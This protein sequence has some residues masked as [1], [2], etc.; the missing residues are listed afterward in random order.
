MKTKLFIL[1][2]LIILS[3]SSQTKAQYGHAD[4]V[5]LQATVNSPKPVRY[6][7]FSLDSSNISKDTTIKA[8]SSSSVNYVSNNNFRMAVFSD[9][10]E[11]LKLYSDGKRA[12]NGQHQP[13]DTTLYSPGTTVNQNVAV[14]MPENRDLV[15]IFSLTTDSSLSY[16]LI[17]INGNN[18]QGSVVISGQQFAP[19][20][21][22]ISI[23]LTKH[24]NGRDYWLVSKKY[25]TNKYVSFRIKPSGNVDT[26]FSKAGSGQYQ[27]PAYGYLKFS[28][29]GQWLG[30][31]IL[32]KNVIDTLRLLN[33][34]AK[35]GTVSD[36]NIRY[37]PCH[38]PSA[39]MGKPQSYAFSPNSRFVYV[40][41]NGGYNNRF[42][43]YDLTTHD[44]QSFFNSRIM[45]KKYNPPYGQ[46][47]E[48][49]MGLTANGKIYNPSSNYYLNA[50]Y[51]NSI[52]SPDSAG[53]AC[54]W[55]DYP[56]IINSTLYRAKYMEFPLFCS[57]WLQ[58]PVDFSYTHTCAGED[59]PP[60]HF[61]LTDSVNEVTWHFSDSATAGPDTS[62]LFHPS[63]KYLKPGQ[64]TVWIKALHYG[65]WD[66]VAK[67]ITIHQNPQISLGQ[68]T[69]LTGNDTL[70]LDPGGGYA[71]YK[72]NTGDTTQTL[73]LYGSQMTAGSHSYWVE[74][75]DSNGCEAKAHRTVTYSG[76]G[77]NEHNADKW[78]V[79][80]NPTEDKLTIELDQALHDKATL[81][82]YD[83]HG[84]IVRRHEW[85]Q[86]DKTKQ[87]NLEGLSKGIYWLE[88]SGEKRKYRQSVMKQ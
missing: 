81:R 7:F 77:I 12:W 10:N 79:Y 14:P 9:K 61:S 35:T 31:N 6:Y 20:N 49:V 54:N 42:Y 37:V 38:N 76:V 4:N 29:D 22:L 57:S 8:Y 34:D 68:D 43:Q 28:P 11:N 85:P 1:I 55:Q 84:A 24:A 86:Q 56:Y 32:K 3:F 36:S 23:A 83:Q 73:T 2:P 67:T 48:G 60:T 80:P 47:N 74:V 71:D 45:I 27:S 82:L 52:E 59:S 65:M 51:M 53:L 15:Y 41:K 13:I 70:V 58:E 63:H 5:V 30:D 26:V 69:T 33:F 64:Y 16:S 50:T 18:G 78:K 75:T 19:Y 39:G 25:F 88:L 72:W 46:D 87:L 44:Q 21:Y 40:F 66:S 17:N 62:T